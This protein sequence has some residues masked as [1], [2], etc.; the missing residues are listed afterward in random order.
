MS[1]KIYTCAS[2]GANHPK[3]SGK[4]DV[5]GEWNSISLE[6]VGDKSAFGFKTKS[7]GMIDPFNFDEKDLSTATRYNT[8]FNE[9]DLVL[10]G[11]LVVGSVALVGG[12][13]GIGKSTLLLQLASKLAINNHKVIYASGEESGSQISLRAERLGITANPNLDVLISNNLLEILNTTKFLNGKVLIIDS[14]QK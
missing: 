10:G 3:W 8:G 6:I 7:I 9:L 4:C 14:I 5:C 11:G 12:D 1:V 2:C 13:P